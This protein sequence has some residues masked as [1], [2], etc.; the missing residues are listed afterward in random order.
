MVH[1]IRPIIDTDDKITPYE[2]VL[3]TLNVVVPHFGS[4]YRV[5]NLE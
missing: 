5:I 1:V 2:V 3:F 4:S